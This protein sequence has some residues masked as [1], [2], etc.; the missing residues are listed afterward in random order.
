MQVSAQLRPTGNA[1]L[2]DLIE[3]IYS[4]ALD[5]SRWTD[6]TE[7]I[8][9]R[10]NFHNLIL[11]LHAV[12]TG[13][14]LLS[15]VLN[16]P[17]EYLALSADA[18]YMP[19]II[20]I[21]GGAQR[22]DRM[23]LEEPVVLHEVTSR[24][25]F[26]RNRYYRDFAA[27]QNIIDSM[28][29]PLVREPSLYGDFSMGRHRD[30]GLVGPSEVASLR[31]LAPHIRRAALVSGILG[32]TAAAVVPFEAAIEATPAGVVLVE[33]D[34]RIVHANGTAQQ[35]LAAGHPIRAADGHLELTLELLPGQLASAVAAARNAATLGRRGI[36][37]PTRR[38]DGSP[39]VVHVMPL[40]P[41]QVRH[42]V[43]PRAVAA[44]FVADPTGP[45]HGHADT[46]GLLFD[47]T[48]TEAQV[49]DLVAAGQS[50]AAIATALGV[51]PS[52]LKTHLRHV[53]EKT[54]RHS[55]ADLVRLAREL[56]LPR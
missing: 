16:V 14:I 49:F 2:A 45:P 18:S 5:P 8:R 7:A 39:L 10:L 17:P 52:T 55:K 4:A 27:P 11:S 9:L 21:W 36:G 20:E 38:A 15:V 22:L 53:F 32:T 12:R 43:S 23:I 28:T 47:L 35:M 30:Q 42:G 51:A 26:E 13:Q 48:P 50:N 41:R 29:I 34:L 6:A 44:V 56:V 54:N 25:A 3:G 24:S 46:L 19:D 33:P 31:I 1:E 37:I 40:L